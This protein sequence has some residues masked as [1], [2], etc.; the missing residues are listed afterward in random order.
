M[1]KIQKISTYLLVIFNVLLISTPLLIVLQWVFI[2]AKITDA[3][4]AI[5]F[6]GLLEKTIQTPEGY[7]NLSTVP[8]TIFSKILG[9]S[10]DI[11]GLLPFVLSLFL[12]K[13]IFKNYQKGE[14]FSV[15]NAINYKKLGWLFLADALIIKSLS[16]TLIVLAITLTNPPGHQYISVQ[17]GTPNLE[18][19]FVGAL[20]V[21]ISWVM[22]EASKLHDEQKFTI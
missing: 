2:Q 8:W 16:N 9:F 12:L 5:N 21:I 6:F 20:L 10:A 22:L 1:N 19:L 3:P 17:F 18:A 4:A 13:S 11:L 15:V 14:I 7:I